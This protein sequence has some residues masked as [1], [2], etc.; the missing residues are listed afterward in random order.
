MYDREFLAIILTREWRHFIIASPH[1]TIIFTDHQN[2]TYFQ[3][4]QK[5]TRQQA[6]WVIKLTMNS[7][8]LYR[9]ISGYVYCTWNYRTM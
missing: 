9:K 8:L 1:T 6:R 5:L 3:S 2:L 4:L 7:S